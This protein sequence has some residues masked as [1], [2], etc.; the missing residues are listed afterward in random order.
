MSTKVHKGDMNIMKKLRF[1][2]VLAVAAL[3]SACGIGKSGSVSKP[4]FAKAGEEVRAEKFAQDLK[5]VLN[6]LDVNKEQLLKSKELKISEKESVNGKHLR[7][8]KA[9]ETISMSQSEKNAAKYDASSYVAVLNAEYSRKGSAKG[10]S[11][12]G[13]VDEQYSDDQQL[14][15]VVW[16][17]TDYLASINETY[18]S[19]DII[20]N[21][22]NVELSVAADSFVKEYV[23]DALELGSAYSMVDMIGNLDYLSLKDFKFYE[24]KNLFTFEVSMEYVFGKLTNGLLEYKETEN[25]EYK[26][27]Y[28]I[29]DNDVTYRYYMVNESKYEYYMDVEGNPSAEYFKEGFRNGDVTELKSVKSVESSYKDAS[30]K[31]EAK[32]VDTVD[33]VVWAN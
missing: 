19:I 1:I 4:K 30:V 31:L 12:D 6:D 5:S 24:A 11:Y 32:N 13:D 26:V 18:K 16:N 25:I 3:L 22:N 20:R 9:V 21:L 33:Y 7:G 28:E 17:D 29:K 8:K 10:L 23:Y 2:P 14:Q 15:K 27:Q